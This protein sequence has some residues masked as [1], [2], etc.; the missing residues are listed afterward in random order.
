MATA[1]ATREFSAETKELGDK[2]VKL[3]LKARSPSDEDE[4]GPRRPW[5]GC[6]Q[7][8]PLRHSGP[9]Q[10]NPEPTPTSQRLPL[11]FY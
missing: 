10:G 1:E 7:E 11:E 5:K 3:T 2:I 4:D 8:S 6:H 9:G